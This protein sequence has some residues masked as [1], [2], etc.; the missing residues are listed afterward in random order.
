MIR[1][2][3]DDL[4]IHLILEKKQ[5]PQ[6]QKVLNQLNSDHGSDVFGRTGMNRALKIFKDDRNNGQ[7]SDNF[8]KISILTR[9]QRHIHMKKTNKMMMQ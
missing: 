8:L 3:Q 6:V 7:Y 5:I 1:A 2:I 4:I 9:V